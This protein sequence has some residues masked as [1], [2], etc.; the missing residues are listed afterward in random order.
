MGNGLV[1]GPTTDR[2]P[3]I[4]ID[5]GTTPRTES[6]APGPIGL[7]SRNGGND[8]RASMAERIVSFARRNRRQRVG[9]GECFTLADRA[10]GG[11]GAK[12]AR[13]YGDVTPEADYVWGTAVALR[14]VQ[15]GDIIQF[16]NYRYDRKVE[17]N[18]P[19]GSGSET[20]EFQEREHH[21]AIV[22]SVGDNGEV[23]VLEQNSPEG[24]AVTRNTLFF[25]NRQTSS[26]GRS[27]TIRVSGTVWFYRAQPR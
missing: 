26:G 17:V 13:D 4:V 7:D 2:S 3:G 21:T 6:P 19:D 11:A 9:D 10:L 27:V 25:S 15:P 20:E 18:N 23:T 12:S 22:E 24:S 5:D 16:R 8:S 14:D 1:P